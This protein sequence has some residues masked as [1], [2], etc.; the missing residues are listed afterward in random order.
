[1]PALIKLER[2]RLTAEY[3]TLQVLIDRLDDEDVMARYSLEE[4]LEEVS[5]EIAAL[6][7][8][9]DGN[10]SLALFFGG[11]PVIGQR[12]IEADFAGAVVR[13]FQDLVAKIMAE[14]AVGLGQRGPVPAR[15]SSTMHI[16]SVVRGSFGFLMEEMND[17]RALIDTSLGNAV[18]K[19]GRILLAFSSD[20][21]TDFEGTVGETD[22]RV[23]QSV[24]DIFQLLNS[25]EA[26]LRFVTPKIDHSFKGEEVDLVL[27]RALTTE[28]LEE[29]VILEG[30]ASGFLPD[31][32][33]Y[34]FRLPDD[35]LRGKVSREVATEEIMQWNREF[36]DRRVSAK[37]LRTS[38]VKDGEIVRH[39]FKLLQILGA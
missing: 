38:V 24:R 18:E 26:T 9:V 16:T 1:M 8:G 5:D 17:Q 7:I 29:I 27:Q 10:A 36:L 15:A 32:H 21:E 37:F 4:R 39:T 34:E 12:G 23:L 35:T 33:M 31:G 6:D 22:N 19:A 30:I 11:K 2:D 3:Q 14:D 25:S 28:V 13:R 20:D